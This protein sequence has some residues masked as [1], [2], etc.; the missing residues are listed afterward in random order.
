MK[1]IILFTFFIAI[2]F[3]A[4]AQYFYLPPVNTGSNP[5]GLNNDD[6]FPFGGGLD[7]SWTQIQGPS[8]TPVWSPVQTIPFTFNFNGS[9]VT[10]YKASTS[11]VVTFTTSASAVPST[12]N[13]ALPSASI[14]DN[15]AMVWGLTG[16][17]SNDNIVTKT[18]GSAEQTTL[19]IFCFLQLS[20]LRRM[21]LFQRGLRRR[22]GQNL[23]C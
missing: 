2:G 15:S 20:R 6:E 14:P 17:G 8:A 22:Y 10:Q 12:S 16:S 21:D 23:F 11:G 13:T 9:P 3:Y 18:F 19:D 4:S 1:K 7:A 5:G